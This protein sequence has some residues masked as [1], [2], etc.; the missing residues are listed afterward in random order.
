MYDVIKTKDGYFLNK[1][2]NEIKEVSSR[3]KFIYFIRGEGYKKTLAF[4]KVA[5]IDVCELSWLEI[6]KIADK[7]GLNVGKEF[8]EYKTCGM[9][10]RQAVRGKTKIYQ[11][12]KE[13]LPND[14]NSE[15]FDCLSS[16]YMLGCF[17]LDMFD[18]VATDKAFSQIDEDYDDC[19]A[20]YK[21]K[22]ISM[23][24]YVE[25]KYGKEYVE[26]INKLIEN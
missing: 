18:V 4:E 19:N 11:K 1:Y 10:A 24:K 2:P 12:I 15:F 16:D 23:N 25:Q 8:A 20:T 26:I 13:I 21:G 17:G 7:Y 9:M 3:K 22:E 14:F 6:V 5:E